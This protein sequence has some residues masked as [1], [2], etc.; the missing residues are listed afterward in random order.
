MP[1][2]PLDI[3]GYFNAKRCFRRSPSRRVHVVVTSAIV[4]LFTVCGCTPKAG[5]RTAQSPD[6]P[7]PQAADVARDYKQLQLLTKEPV[8]VDP[9]LAMLCRGASQGEVEEARKHS[10]PHAH[11]AVSIYMNTPAAE[12]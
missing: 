6:V 2:P 8:Y 4:A 5:T 7:P 11:T 12:T 3:F 9:M 10:G 1:H